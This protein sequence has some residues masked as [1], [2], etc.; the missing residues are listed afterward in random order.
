M[1]SALLHMLSASDSSYC[2]CACRKKSGC[3]CHSSSAGPVLANKPS[4]CASS[5]VMRSAGNRCCI[6]KQDT[7]AVAARLFSLERTTLLLQR[8]CKS[9]L[10]AN[11]L[12][13][14][15]YSTVAAPREGFWVIC[16]WHFVVGGECRQLQR[17]CP[18]NLCFRLALWKTQAASSSGR[19]SSLPEHGTFRYHLIT[20]QSGA[21][22]SEAD[23]L[24][25]RFRAVP[26]FRASQPG[27]KVSNVST[28][29]KEQVRACKPD[30]G[31]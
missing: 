31:A 26:G 10:E 30:I 13:H 12:T 4:L 16:Q 15:A 25:F 6:C 17:A 5:H 14:D 2:H 24:K 22:P 7:R 21:S 19:F 11:Q 28:F 8:L 1:R 20:A 18:K 3:Q 29:C 9:I 23:V 27:M